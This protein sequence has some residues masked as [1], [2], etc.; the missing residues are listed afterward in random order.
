MN[1]G[2]LGALAVE[3]AMRSGSAASPGALMA[4]QRLAGNQAVAG[5]LLAASL[6]DGATGRR[7]SLQR[8]DIMDDQLAEEA[9]PIPAE[10]VP[11]EEA[12]VPLPGGQAPEEQA[13]GPAPG[14]VP[15]PPVPVPLVPGPPVPGPAAATP[16][17]VAAARY[18]A[19]RQA[20]VNKRKAEATA[21][22]TTA[23]IRRL[24]AAGLTSSNLT[25]RHTVKAL[26]RGAMPWE[27]FTKHGDSDSLGP[28]A[29][30]I[31]TF[32]GLTQVAPGE[33]QDARV[34]GEFGG[35]VLKL[36]AHDSIGDGKMLGTIVHEVSHAITTKQGPGPTAG[37][38]DFERFADEF[39]SFWAEAEA[40]SG[41]GAN[42]AGAARGAAIRNY[43]IRVYEYQD[44]YRDPVFKAKVDGVALNGPLRAN[45]TN[46]LK[47]AEFYQ[48]I[49]R[50]PSV[51]EAV[52]IIRT[53]G[54]DDRSAAAGDQ[55]LLRLVTARNAEA[56]ART[57]ISTLSSA[58]TRRM[59]PL[60]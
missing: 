15:V 38:G 25:I 4:L 26:T 47:I 51:P 39:Q 45:K 41:P 53:M 32:T 44:L 13:A 57:I 10:P 48:E 14:P 27:V 49:R 59:T 28:P 33:P 55:T 29:G 54:A 37:S 16:Y 31:Y 5:L 21:A 30:R 24:I 58:W 50:N 56:D 46:S 23:Q 18:V 42:L 43:V 8:H 12:V 40:G 34:M 17:D 36:R 19:R 3:L 2:T 52:A 22:N 9:P 60:P 35:S 6:G 11:A 7:L 1:R 20:E